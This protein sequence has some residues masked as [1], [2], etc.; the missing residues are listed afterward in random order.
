MENEKMDNPLIRAKVYSKAMEKMSSLE[1]LL[2]V[3][4]P[5]WFFGSIAGLIAGQHNQQT[6]EKDYSIHKALA[7]QYYVATS[8]GSRIVDNDANGIPEY[9]ITSMAAPRWGFSKKQ[10]LMPEDIIIYK[11]AYEKYVTSKSK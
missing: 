8:M 3:T 4:S 6:K 1:K 10:E 11:N 5:I 9:R 7:G 2:F